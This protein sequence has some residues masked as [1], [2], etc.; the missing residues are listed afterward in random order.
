LLEVKRKIEGQ[1]CQDVQGQNRCERLSTEVQSRGYKMEAAE[2][3]IIRLVQQVNA[4]PTEVLQLIESSVANQKDPNS[5]RKS[6]PLVC[7]DRY[8]DKDGI[9]R[10]GGRIRRAKVPENLRHPAVLP[11]KGHVTQLL[12]Y[13]YH[14]KTG[15]AL[16]GR[17]TTMGELRSSGIWILSARSSIISCLRNCVICKRLRGRPAAQKMGDLPQDRITEAPPF[18]NSGVDYFGPFPVPQGCSNVKRWGVLFTCLSSRAIHLEVTHSMSTDSFINAYRRF[19]CRRGPCRFLRSDRGSNFV[20]TNGELEAALREM[21]NDAIKRQ[22][23]K[24]DCDWPVYQKCTGS[25][26]ISAWISA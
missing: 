15:H 23:L 5:I 20:G 4:F 13:H 19:V 18:S 8:V 17:G 12:V 10:V 11:K 26:S 7:L 16:P 1:N 14:R 2:K 22:L 21:D 3:V 24:D 6:S 25:T 9:I